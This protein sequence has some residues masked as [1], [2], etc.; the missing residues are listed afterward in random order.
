MTSLSDRE[1]LR[2]LAGQ[3]TEVVTSDGMNRRRETWRLSNELKERTVPFVIEDNG[4]FFQDLFPDLQCEGESERGFE[5]QLLRTIINVELIDDDRVFTP[6]FSVGWH[7]GRP[8]ICP[9]LKIHSV[10]DVTGK[11]LGYETN[12]PLADLESGLDK[13]QRGPFT[14]DRKATYKRKE[15][16]EAI[17]GDLLPIE[18][19]CHGTLSAGSSMAQ[20][21]VTLMGMERFYLAMLDQPENVHRFF[22]FVVTEGEDYLKWLDDEGLITPNH[23]EYVCG[24][25]SYAYCD[26]LPR[27]EIGEGE[28]YHPV[29]CW[30]FVEAQEAVGISNDMYA[31]F[32]FPYQYRVGHQY[33]LLYYGCCE[34]VHILWPTI[35]KFKNLRKMTISPWCDQRFMADAV[36]KNYVLSRKPHPL[37]LCSEIFDPVE[38]EEHIQETLDIAKDNF[39]ELVFRDTCPLNGGMKDR[40]SEAC[41]IVRSLIDRPS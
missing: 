32:I 9:D 2:A 41:S 19:V 26:E 15:A 13:L 20:K 10:P 7:I 21:A 1:R 40:V 39:V 25:G 37:K 23:T 18:I 33:G 6:F 35:K 14:I 29:D 34:P 22:D 30:G 5:R 12:M 28:A 16:A 36:G 31:E 3:Y 27:R 24:S 4:S 11:N 38:F 8:S 17:F